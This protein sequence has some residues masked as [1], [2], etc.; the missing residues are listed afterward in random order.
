MKLQAVLLG[1]A[2]AQR[3]LSVDHVESPG[4]SMNAQSY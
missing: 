3:V 1:L 4:E 2:L